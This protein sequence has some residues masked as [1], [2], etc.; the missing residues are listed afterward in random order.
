MK[1][2]SVC[3]RGLREHPDTAAG[4]R[5][6]LSAA[7]S[8]GP[9]DSIYPP[10]PRPP[11]N[12]AADRNVRAPGLAAVSKCALGLLAF[13]QLAT[14]SARGWDY[15]YHRVINEL[16]LTCLPTNFPGFARTPAAT[17]RIGFLAGEPDRWR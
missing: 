3:T 15:P 5:T 13:V 17:E 16:A 11:S 9:R 7:T 12:A 2:T 8:K 10:G 6:F 1:R 4:A 14:Q